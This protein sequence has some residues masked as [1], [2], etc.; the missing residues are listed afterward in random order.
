MTLGFEFKQ[1]DKCCK[2][3]LNWEHVRMNGFVEQ[4]IDQAFYVKVEMLITFPWI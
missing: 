3:Y 1:L 2:F 4:G